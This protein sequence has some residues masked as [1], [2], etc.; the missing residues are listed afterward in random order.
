[1]KRTQK[2]LSSEEGKERSR[3]WAAAWGAKMGSEYFVE[4]SGKQGQA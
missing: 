4:C 2:W 1:M 3:M